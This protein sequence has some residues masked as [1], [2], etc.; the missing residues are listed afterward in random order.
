MPKVSDLTNTQRAERRAK[1]LELRTAGYTLAQVGAALGISDRAAAKMIAR[2]LQK[3]EAPLA[4]GVREIELDRLDAAVK[5]VMPMLT[6]EWPE[7]A[8][9]D[10]KQVVDI[11]AAFVDR[12]LAAAEKIA[13]LGERRARLLGLD[14]PV[15]TE[16]N[17]ALGPALTAE[18]VGELVD[19][20]RA[21][22]AKKLPPPDGEP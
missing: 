21:H 12:R 20:I 18:Q 4:E 19:G 22:L 11:V 17:M 5:A 8:S 16:T 14:A 9:A 13:K 2:V 10:Q 1:A 6:G 3:R 7:L 15:K